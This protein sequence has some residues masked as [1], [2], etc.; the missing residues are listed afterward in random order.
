MIPLTEEELSV[1]TPIQ[2]YVLSR[3]AQGA[4]YEQILNEKKEIKT[5]KVLTS[6]FRWT[7]F[8]RKYDLGQTTGRPPTIGDVQMSIFKKEVDK[9]CDINKAITLFEAVTL[10]EQIQGDYIWKNYNLAKDIGLKILSYELLDFEQIFIQRSYL[11]QFLNNNGFQI[12][13]PEKLEENRNKYCHSQIII[14]FY[15]NFISHIP[16]NGN[17]VFNGNKTASLFNE[18]GK[19]IC[20]KG[21]KSI[22][23]SETCNYHFTSFCCYNATG[24]KILRPFIILPSLKKF[25]K[26]LDFFSNQAF[27]VSTP[28]GW[29]TKKMFIAFAV[30]FCNEI[31]LFRIKFLRIFGSF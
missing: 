5:P 9:R 24:T 10:L 1:F 12:K 23:Y 25:P 17:I 28:S 15:S 2:I 29:I 14:D 31:S 11:T 16:Q 3:K 20:S 6:I 18:K 19:V 21:K 13:T 8:G 4:T 22:K 30:F 7:L 26:D 27:F